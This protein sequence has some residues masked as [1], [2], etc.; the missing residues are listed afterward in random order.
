MGTIFQCGEVVLE[1]T[2]VGKECHQHCEIFHRVGDC[3]MPR[4]GVF[5]RVLRGGT[6]REGDELVITSQPVEIG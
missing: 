6:I 1:M 5:A 2:Q 3:I 4:E